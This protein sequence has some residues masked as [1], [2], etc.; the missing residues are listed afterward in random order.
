MDKNVLDKSHS[1]LSSFLSKEYI[2]SVSS[3]REYKEFKYRFIKNENLNCFMTLS[4]FGSGFAFAVIVLIVLLAEIVGVGN[5][6]QSGQ[7]LVNNAIYLLPSLFTLSA[8]LLWFSQSTINMIKEVKVPQLA[9]IQQEEVD[10]NIILKIVDYKNNIIREKFFC[11]EESS[12]LM[13]TIVEW[14]NE[15]V[16]W[17]EENQNC[18]SEAK[19]ELYDEVDNQNEVR[20]LQETIRP[21]LDYSN[22]KLL[23]KIE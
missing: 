5:L 8:S 3:V 22:Q 6:R 2:K 18:I 11:V 15:L 13:E 20:S 19:A 1:D 4:G 10:G 9:F 14:E 12:E 21:L 23:N 17:F 7:E 16:D